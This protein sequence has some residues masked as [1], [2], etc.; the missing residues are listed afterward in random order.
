[1]KT[2]ARQ[3]LNALL[4]SLLTLASPTLAQTTEPGDSVPRERSFDVGMYLGKQW[5]INLTLAARQP[6]RI[7]ITLKDPSNTVLYRESLKKRQTKYWRGFN[8]DGVAA[9]TYQFEISDGRQTIVRRIEVVDM[10]A[11]EAQRYIT[12]N[13]Y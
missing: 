10:P 6:E 7:M 11:V 5:N 8:F 4:V 12:Y 9:G 13:L 3:S 2:I 1:M